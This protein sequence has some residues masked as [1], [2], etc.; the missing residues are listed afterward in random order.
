ML[1]QSFYMAGG[2]SREGRQEGRGSEYLVNIFNGFDAELLAEAFQV[3]RDLVRKM[4]Q[5]SSREGLIVKCNEEMS[6]LRPDEQE[7]ELSSR[8]GVEET[9]CTRKI[10]YD[11]NTHKE[12]DLYSREAGRVNIVNEHKLPILRFLGISAEKAH[13]FPV[14]VIVIFYC[15]LLV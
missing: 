4:Q 1:D 3:P 12:S 7:E 8:N 11:M 2:A 9:V 6:F 14:I 5:G 13:L 10:R 15:F